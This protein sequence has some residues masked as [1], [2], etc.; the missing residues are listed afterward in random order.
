LTLSSST[1]L[2]ASIPSGLSMALT[3]RDA[4]TRLVT[5]IV[6]AT[7]I[8]DTTLT[9]VRAQEGT[10]A[11]A[12]AT[13]DYAYSG[14]TAGQMT[15][16]NMGR[17]LGQ[18]IPF[19]SSG[20]YTPS[21]GARL[22]RIQ[23]V[24]AGGAGGGSS[25]NPSTNCTACSGGG[26]GSYVDAWYLASSLGSSVAVG[27]GAGAIGGPGSGNTGGTTTFG[28]FMSL[29]GGVGGGSQSYTTSVTNYA[30]QGVGGGAP[31]V[32]GALYSR[33]QHGQPGPCGIVFTGQCM[34]GQGGMSPLGAGGQNI[35]VGAGIPGSGYGAGGG[36]AGVPASVGPY[37]GGNGSGG[38][39]EIT[40][41]S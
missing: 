17:I 13:G 20:T 35:A 25:A 40:E 1:G 21:A 41:Y 22:V 2:P 6:Y 23:A 38:Y 36:G 29:P 32:S 11:A 3:L 34:P 33:Q 27:I 7:A 15:T 10:A 30:A 4:A 19:T 31:T 37:N 18:P 12:W 39:V 9:V 14:P 28:S 8:S 16:V 24:G 5:E 26:A